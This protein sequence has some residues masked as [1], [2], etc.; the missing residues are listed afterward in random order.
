MII[1]FI[2]YK[3]QNVILFFHIKSSIVVVTVITLAHFLVFV[4]LIS[5]NTF[6]NIARLKRDS[7]IKRDFQ[8]WLINIGCWRL[9]QTS[10]FLLQTVW[11]SSPMFFSAVHCLILWRHYVFLPMFSSLRFI[12]L[13]AVVKIS[14]YPIS[15]CGRGMMFFCVLWW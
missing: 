9:F 11:F 8:I 3:N 15:L 2:I 7:Y 10:F 6:K 1:D 5:Y 12:P 14:I 13:L 4:G